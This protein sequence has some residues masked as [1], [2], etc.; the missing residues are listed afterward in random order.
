MIK[1]PI[2]QKDY[3][4]LFETTLEPASSVVDKLLRKEEI[5]KAEIKNIKGR[6]NKVSVGE[7][8][9]EN[10]YSRL[11]GEKQKIPHE[12]KQMMDNY[13]F[14][15]ISLCCSFLPDRN[16][17]FIWA[18]FG[19][20]FNAVSKEASKSLKEKP[21]AYDMSPD[22]VLSRIVYKDYVSLSPELKLE[23]FPIKTG[24]KVGKAATQKKFIIHEPQIFAFGLRTPS[25]AW[26]FRD[27]SEKGIWGNKRD[28]LLIV[29]TPKN[30][31]VK[32]RF[33]FGVEVEVSVGMGRLVSIP[34][35]R[36]KDKVIDT[37]YDLSN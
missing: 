11:T 1:L 32:G 30:S 24:M 9:Y 28:L 33:I 8:Y 29:K 16:C 5:G 10:V 25:I 19:V 18:R 14:H 22:E 12:I 35:R 17:K 13:D 27:T 2:L 6:I 26:E 4:V 21:I 3:K 37:E 31:K 20:E 23:L 15:F 7:P 36:K 34:Y